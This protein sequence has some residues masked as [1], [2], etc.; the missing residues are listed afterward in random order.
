MHHLCLNCADL[1]SNNAMGACAKCGSDKIRSHAELTSLNIA[2]VDCDSFFASVEKRDNPQLANKPVVVGGLDGGVVCAACYVAREFGIHSAMPISQAKKL[3]PKVM[4]IQP[5]MEV[6]SQVGGQIRD[7][8]FD[9]TPQVEPL[10]I[11][12][13]F[14]D[15]SGLQS[16]TGKYPAQLM[17]KLANRIRSEIGVT[18]SVGLSFNKFLAKTA[19]DLDKPNGFFAI[20]RQEAEEFLSDR[21]IDSLY[22]VGPATAKKLKE[23]M[24]FKIGDLRIYDKDYLFKDFGAKG[25]LLY[26]FCRGVDNRPVSTD[27][28]RKSVGK[29]H[30]FGKKISNKKVLNDYFIITC[31]ELSSTLKSKNIVARTLTLKLKSHYKGAITRSITLNNATNLYYE[32]HRNLKPIY[33]K[34][35][36][37]NTGY[38]LLGVSASNLMDYDGVDI[39]DLFDSD[40]KYQAQAERL[41]DNINDKFSQDIIKKGI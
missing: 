6:Y 23:M 38:T 33:D 16:L 14:L 2:H 13:A 15:L 34:E 35:I 41:V 39:P 4:V 26:D 1:W 19:S 37:T 7:L 3:C 28:K 20:G 36:G 18:V 8:F 27:S 12:E 31:K 17:V 29:E 30:S 24:V 32:I 25:Y 9:T 5:R 10:S 11:D 22:G 40:G 21:P